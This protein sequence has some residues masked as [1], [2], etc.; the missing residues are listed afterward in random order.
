MEKLSE[1]FP[2]DIKHRIT[3][4]LDIFSAHSTMEMSF[5]DYCQYMRNQHDETPLYIF[6]AR[7]GEK[8]PAMLNDYSVDSLGVFRQD[9][10]K[11]A[12]ENQAKEAAKAE[13]DNVRFQAGG[14]KIQDNSS[15]PNVNKKKSKHGSIRPD[16]RWIVIGPERTG[17]PWHTDPART[18]AWNSLV[19]GRKRWAIYPPDSPPPGV[20]IGK[21][22]QNREHALNMT[23]LMWYLHVYPTLSPEQKPWEI[24]QEEGET[25]YVPSGWWHLVL[26]L[27]E[28]IAVT[29]NFVDSHNALMFA[30][31]L[32]NDNE[33]EA[34]Q[35]FQ[36]ELKPSHPELYDVFR[37]VQIPRGHGY[38][39]EEMYINSF[40]IV[41]YWKSPLKKVYTRHQ[42]ATLWSA[43][44][45]AG[46][47]VADI[48]GESRIPKLKSLTS[49]ANPTFAIGKR[50]IVKFFSQFNEE[51]SEFDLESFLAPDFE[52]SGNQ[53]EGS[54]SK[55]R[56]TNE[57]L[58]TYELKKSM[59]L[60][61]A[62]E[63]CYRVEKSAYEMISTNKELAR[64]V[65]KCY[66]SGHLHHI[67][68]VDDEDGDGPMW[69]WPYIVSEYKHD[70][71]GLGV[72]TKMGGATRQS[73]QQ[74]ASWISGEFLPKLHAVP[75]DTELRG[76]HGHPKSKWDWYLHYL[77]RQRKRALACT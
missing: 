41:D 47:N 46:D 54:S 24:I 23:S 9:F 1:R 40:K 2:Q 35:I 19:K 38:F 64:F 26:N 43:Q 74:T 51:W 69:R 32:L 63:E 45:R 50:A 76:L 27:D 17:A 7:F 39:S 3:H 62:M 12:A 48:R 42:L 53:V 75:I 28:T 59:S 60:R 21:N 11:D 67:D 13:A 37:L 68:E 77:L 20:Q 73:W 14:K 58:D 34:L 56:R 8:M 61:F 6:D 49:R 15:K 16:F 5:A 55:K 44:K 31:D 4:N 33:D 36:H 57:F 22:G 72:V 18:S 66:N 52:S 29:Q 25:I 10:L 30:K 71:V 65:P 70:L